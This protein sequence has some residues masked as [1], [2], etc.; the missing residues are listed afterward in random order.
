M[1]DKRGW[2]Y[3]VSGAG[4]YKIG[5]T[6]APN[7]VAGRLSALQGSSPVPLTLEMSFEVDLCYA[8]ERMLHD[9][10]RH[11]SVPLVGREWFALDGLD[12]DWIRNMDLPTLL[13]EHAPRRG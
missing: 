7:G 5:R 9:Q 6:T 12:L 2:V 3:V 8:T 11:K 4:L 10:F 1:A 13:T